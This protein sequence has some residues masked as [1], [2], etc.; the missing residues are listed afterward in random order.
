MRSSCLFLLLFTISP[1]SPLCA[2]PGD[3]QPPYLQSLFVTYST[4]L[5]TLG[6]YADTQGFR[7]SYERKSTVLHELIHID[8]AT[9]AAYRIKGQSFDP[10]NQPLA[11]PTYRFVQFRESVTASTSFNTQAITNT[12]VFNLYVA[13]T[14]NNTLASLADELN[15]YGQSTDWL[16][17]FAPVDERSKSTHSMRDILRVTN[18]FLQTLR[19]AEPNQY[20]TFYAK[21]KSARNLL[22]LTIFN[23]LASLSLCGSALPNYDRNELDILVE[24]AKK[25]A[26]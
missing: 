21:Q 1:S 15:A 11:W 4:L 2:A 3:S 20:S 12:P 22:A 18:A 6:S 14:P 7:G 9:H 17:R 5:P 23:A 26:L 24:L 10:Y 13:N 8:S 19:S 25:E 16:C